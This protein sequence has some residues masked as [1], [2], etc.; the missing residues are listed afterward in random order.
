MKF[1]RTLF[2]RTLA[3]FAIL[4]ACLLFTACGNWAQDTLN[5]LNLLGPA[6]A[7]LLQIL[8]SLGVAVAPDFM[9]KFQKWVAEA[10]TGVTTVKGLIEQFKTVVA[11]AQGAIVGEIQAVLKTTSD[12]LTALLPELHITN[13]NTQAHVL[14]VFAA[15]VGMFNA[16][17][18][19]IPAAKSSL[20][21]KEENPHH[22]AVLYHAY[23]TKAKNFR[24]DFNAAAHFFG[25]QYEI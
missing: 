8:A 7:A 21:G 20:E 5:V 1:N 12:N 4:D 6:M 25:K 13:P 22:M 9:T 16:A 19:F 23:S 10:Q 11:S 17:L 18:A 15:I 24:K 14:A 2:L 3:V